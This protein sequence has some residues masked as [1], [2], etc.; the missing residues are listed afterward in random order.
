MT[1]PSKL[2]LV[3]MAKDPLPGQVKTRLSPPLSPAEAAGLYR[4][5]LEDRIAE[6]G[7]LE[8]VD[9]ALAYTPGNAKPTFRA[10]VSDSMQLFAQRGKNL[11]E[12]LVN[13]FNDLFSEGYQSVSIIDSDTPDLSSAIMRQSFDLLASEHTDVVFGPCKDGGYYLV[14]LK[15]NYPKLF[16]KIPW[17]GKNVLAVSLKKA[18]EM[19]L[20]TALLP[21]Q[22]DID[23]YEDLLNFYHRNK[24]SASDDDWPGKKTFTF[25]KNRFRH[26][27]FE[28]S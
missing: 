19:G 7:T 23:T 20:Q 28:T 10:L 24:E 13:I 16:E 6:V 18:K 8:G 14:G 1:K 17:S 25:L 9:P 11:T 12:E 4:C 21:H 15:K 27:R 3:I 5:F 22:N 2:S 26:K